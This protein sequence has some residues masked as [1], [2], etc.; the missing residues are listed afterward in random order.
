MFSYSDFS[1]VVWNTAFVPFPPSKHVSKA[2]SGTASSQ[3]QATFEE[4]S[5]SSCP[6]WTSEQVRRQTRDWGRQ[7]STQSQRGGGYKCRPG[8]RWG[9]QTCPTTRTRETPE[10]P[11]RQA[12]GAAAA[13][14]SSSQVGGF[15]TLISDMFFSIYIHSWWVWWE[16][17]P[18]AKYGLIYNF[19]WV[20][21]GL[22]WFN[23]DSE[24]CDVIKTHDWCNS[25]C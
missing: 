15:K 14:A 13:A 8:S 23:H 12:E 10:P 21:D 19:V 4:G 22:S 20:S 11:R 25:I 6:Q 9:G 7:A 16:L 3:R 1:S 24:G 2:R 18:K 17:N 5:Q